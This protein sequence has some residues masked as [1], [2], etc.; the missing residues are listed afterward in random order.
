MRE[1]GRKERGEEGKRGGRLILIWL[2]SL[3]QF[4]FQALKQCKE[5]RRNNEAMNSGEKNRTW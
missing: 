2:N 4:V 5:E 1:G 3:K